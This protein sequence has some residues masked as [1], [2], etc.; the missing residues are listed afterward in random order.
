MG[1][2]FPSTTMTL[3]ATNRT[4]LVGYSIEANRVN[5]KYAPYVAQFSDLVPHGSVVDPIEH[6]TRKFVTYRENLCFGGGVGDAHDGVVVLP[7]VD[8]RGQ[9]GGC[10]EWITGEK[11]I[12]KISKVAIRFTV[13]II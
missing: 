3:Y 11:H 8:C 5:Y 13:A 12:R 2:D 6:V 7:T 4:H 9:R 10:D 1:G